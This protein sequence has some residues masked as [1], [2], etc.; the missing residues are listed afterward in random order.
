[1]KIDLFEMERTQCLYE[2]TVEFNL[3]ESGVL[4]LSVNELNASRS[5]T[6]TADPKMSLSPMAAPMPIT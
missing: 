3:S 4:P 1:M 6:R 2:R 5:S